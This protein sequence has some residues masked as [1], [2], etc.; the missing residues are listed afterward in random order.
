VAEDTVATID[1]QDNDLVLNVTVLILSILDSSSHGTIAVTGDTMLTYTP[2]ADY[3][4]YDTV[5]YALNGITAADTGLVFITVVNEDDVPVVVDPISD[6]TVNEDTPDTMLADLDMVFMDIDDELEY[7]HT[8]EDT[9]LV[10]VAVTNDMVTLQFL[11]DANGSTTIIFTATNPTIR[12]SV[13]DT[14]TVT[15]LPVNDAPV[16]A[17]VADTTID[18]DTVIDIILNA[19]DVDEDVLTFSATTDT[20]T[21]IASVNENLLSLSPAGNWNGSSTIIAV[22]SDGSVTDTTSFELTI[23][24]V[25]DAPGD[26]MMLSPENDAI[27]SITPGNIS[28][29]LWFE[30]AASIDVDG[31]SLTYL[32]DVSSEMAFLETMLQSEE[33]TSAW[34]EYSVL[35]EAI[36]SLN[37]V[38]GA[39][40]IAVTDGI[41]SVD[42]SN[43]QYSFTI[44]AT[45][46]AIDPATL[47]PEVFALH[48]N[49]PNPF[50]PTTTLRYDL[51]EDANVNI[52]IYDMMGRVVKTMVNTQQNAG[53]KSVRWN[54]TNDKGAP[55]SAGLY[56][57]TIEAGEYRQT[58]KMVLLK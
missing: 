35:A 15:I 40:I 55:V 33:S 49:Y 5:Q 9:T 54:A 34:V 23:N 21:V 36:D 41:D 18:E 37:V 52:T 31:D 43:G 1:F 27:I 46:M 25:N 44:D 24:T 20:S 30:W 10:F 13:S 22:V 53:F 14:M 7:S 51:P 8:I 50:N 58:R 11:P 26:F 17:T 48:Q 4:G 38:T 19:N 45:S 39:W 16:L 6:L 42:A 28:D 32:F 2:A 47:I 12:A 57:Y 29:T 3:F 56:L